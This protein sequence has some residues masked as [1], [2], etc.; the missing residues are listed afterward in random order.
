MIYLSSSLILLKDILDLIRNNKNSSNINIT[1]LDILLYIDIRSL[2]QQDNN[3][4]ILISEASTSKK[5][6]S[7][8]LLLSDNNLKDIRLKLLSMSL[9]KY[10][11]YSITHTSDHAYN[12]QQVSMIS[13]CCD[14][15]AQQVSIASRNNEVSI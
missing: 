12:A 2:Y 11:R 5:D 14:H 10:R 1:S 15:N 7:L 6:D 4:S 13:R 3:N 8:L 9:N